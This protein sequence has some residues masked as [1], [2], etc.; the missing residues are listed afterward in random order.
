MKN[1]TTIQKTLFNWAEVTDPQKTRADQI[2]KEF[3]VYHK[4]HPSVWK[5]F[6]RLAFIEINKGRKKFSSKAICEKI[7]W[8]N[9]ASTSG[10]NLNNFTAYYA[11]LFHVAV[12]EHE[13]F[14]IVRKLISAD[15]PAYK[16]AI[17]EFVSL[18][19]QYEGE[20]VEK[21]EKILLETNPTE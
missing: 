10:G 12:P 3:E 11:R 19:A 7:R 13:N 16:N 1:A 20:L 15:K 17:G 5:E 6:V 9:A 21:L 18:P 14:F 8:E 2:F 4:T